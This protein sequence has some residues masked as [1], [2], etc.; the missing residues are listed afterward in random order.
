MVG[1]NRDRPHAYLVD[2]SLYVFRAWHS[3]PP[4]FTDVDGH[5]VNAVHGFTRF[6]LDLLERAK[7]S[8]A[9]ICFDESL[10]SSFRNAIYPDYKANRE[11]P[12]DELIRQFAYCREVAAALGMTVLTDT[13]FEADD[14]IGS[15]VHALDT[16]DCGAIIV[17]ADKDFGQLVGDSVEQWDFSRDQR[18]NAQGIKQRLG[19]HPHQ[20]ADFL[21]LMGDAIDNIPGIPGIGAKTAAVLLAHFE[22]LDALLE[23]REEVAFLR[24]RGAAGIARKLYEHA[25]MA[26]LSRRLTGIAVDAPVP[27]GLTDYARRAPDEA[28][29]GTLFDRLK[30]GPMTRSRVR[31]LAS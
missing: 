1:M 3:I 15:A 5:P 10:T 14:L 21:A 26:R 29:I 19:V 28:A 6:L 22:T 30:L 27:R 9:A 25:D 20:V 17:S 23:R 18:W 11:L 8:H 16:H 24:M 7:P 13:E 4:D 12:P 31:S 2:A